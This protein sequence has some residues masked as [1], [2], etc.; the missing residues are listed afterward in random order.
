[1]GNARPALRGRAVRYP[2]GRREVDPTGKL[3]RGPR[4]RLPMPPRRRGC[5]P[6]GRAAT[7][8]VGLALRRN[9]RLEDEPAS[10][11]A[12]GKPGG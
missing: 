3:R 7:P 12:P 9:D 8:V 11:G 10:F 1:M 6:G 4:L 5:H 2:C